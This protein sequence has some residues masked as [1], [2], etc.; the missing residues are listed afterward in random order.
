MS[1]LAIFVDGGY[2]EALA[3]QQFG[4]GRVDF[5]ELSGEIHRRVVA[6][7]PGPV[8][9][10]RTYYYDCPPYQSRTPTDDERERYRRKRSFLHRL[11]T[12]PRYHVREGRLQYQGKDAGGRSI[13]Q[14]KGVDLLLGLDVAVLSIKQRISHAV[15][16]AGDSDFL[17]AVAV[18]KQEG[19]LMW[20]LH[21]PLRGSGGSPT[22][23]RELW[24][25]ADER[26]E[27]DNAFMNAVRRT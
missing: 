15:L 6:A 25:E 8:D 24:L 7:S 5:E 11:A 9:L 3:R 21:G 20:L 17:P 12:I 22:Y 1:R 10:L 4:G 23:S 14:Q 18:A 2:V 26:I 13:F 16:V 27:F 19:V